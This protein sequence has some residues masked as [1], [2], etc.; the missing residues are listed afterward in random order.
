MKTALLLF[1]FGAA[2]VIGSTS[3]ELP[4]LKDC[5]KEIRSQ[6]PGDIRRALLNVTFSAKTQK[7]EDEKI[8]ALLA[9]CFGGLGLTFDAD[10]NDT[11]YEVCV[12]DGKGEQKRAFSFLYNQSKDGWVLVA[13]LHGGFPVG[14]PVKRADGWRDITT[15]DPIPGRPG[16]EL[17]RT[18]RHTAKGYEQIS[19]SIASGG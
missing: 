12:Y 6:L 18:Y 3:N 19:E 15:R 9:K 16:A 14:S 1:L 2:G 7:E 17:M 10:D 5:P 8:K 13:A 4:R 11:E